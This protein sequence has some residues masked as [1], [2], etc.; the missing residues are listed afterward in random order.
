MIRIF[1]RSLQ[2]IALVGTLMVGIVAVAL[3]VSQTPWF[4]DWLRRYVV[5]E[6]KQYLNGELSIGRI[7]GNLLFGVDLSDVAVD[8]SGER[9]VAVKTV[10]VDYSIFDLISKGIVLDEI[11]LASPVIRIERDHNGWNLGRLVKAQAK[12]KDR[13]GP[14]RPISLPRIEIADAS[15]SID[16][17]LGANGYHLPARVDGLTVKAGYAY[18]PVHYSIDIDHLSFRASSPQLNLTALTGKIA[19]RED[20]L[21]VDQVSVR[22]AE[23]SFTIDGVVEKYLETPIVKVTTTGRASLPEFGRV[24]PAAAGYDLHPSFNVRAA[25]P[26]DNLALTLDV[27]SEAGNVRGDVTTDVRAPNLAVRG[28]VD[29]EKLDLAPILKNPAQ[30]TDLTGHA[31]V[32]LEMA[33]APASAPA[34]SRMSGTYKFEGPRVVAAGYTA[35]H[36]RATGG[37]SGGRITVD[38]RAAA[39]GGSGTARGFIAPPVGRQP[40]AIRLARVGCRCR[41]AQSAGANR[42]AG[43]GNRAICFGIS[44]RR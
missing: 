25:G 34:F 38:A 32:D 7:G 23:S 17:S 16:D 4:R 22:T 36:V 20:N 13:E 10:E 30:K 26:A 12:E 8:V 31:D 21:Y 18:A 44:R 19:V 24:F 42:C 29:V 28:G 37:L 15:V 11:K 35:T 27:K 2:V 9:V 14:R 40:A 39:Y 6:S 5:R 3:I 41:S 1:R 43:P 33:S